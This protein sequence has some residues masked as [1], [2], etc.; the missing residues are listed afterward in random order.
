MPST[1]KTRHLVGFLA[2][3]SITPAAQAAD[4]RLGMIG[5]DTG[6]VIEFTTILHVPAPKGHVAGA[7][8][9]AAYRAASPTIESSWTKVGGYTE[10]R[11]QEYGVK[12]Y[13]SIEELVNNVDGVLIESVDAR[14]HLAQAS[15]VIRAGKPLVIENPG[16][17]GLERRLARR[18][19]TAHGFRRFRYF[20]RVKIGFSAQR[21]RL[22]ARAAG[23]QACPDGSGVA[24]TGSSDIQTAEFLTADR[25]D[26]AGK[27]R[28]IPDYPVRLRSGPETVEWPHRLRYPPLN[29]LAVFLAWPRSV[30]CGANLCAKRSD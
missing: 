27:G 18:V 7:R 26:E 13:N 30:A 1:H 9:V 24:P 4:L 8:V 15:A 3:A 16:T 29:A 20:T 2:L 25:A 10:K 17:G 19:W 11:Q 14:P 28:G 22:R 21:V 6:H 12:L 5:L 23:W